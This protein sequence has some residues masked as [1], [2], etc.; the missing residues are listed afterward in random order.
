MIKNKGVLFVTHITLLI[1]SAGYDFINW[2]V[3]LFT[4]MSQFYLTGL[5]HT[6]Y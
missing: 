4:E 2:Y 6:I 5:P 1:I 3:Q